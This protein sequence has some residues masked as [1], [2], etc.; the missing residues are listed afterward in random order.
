MIKVNILGKAEGFKLPTVLGLDLNRLSLR[1]Y[2]AVIIMWYVADYAVFET[3]NGEVSAMK[4][5][6]LM[7]QNE[8]NQLNATI[9]KNAGIKSQIEE[10]K[11]Q[12]ERLKNRSEQVDKI[13]QSKSNPFR[14]LERLARNIPEDAWFDTIKFTEDKKVIIEGAAISH[15]SIGALITVANESS[16]FGKSLYI[17]DTS[18]VEEDYAGGKRRVEKFVIEGN[19]VSFDPWGN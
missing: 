16:Y 13:F 5:K 11:A 10:F 6:N 18:T 14:V 4:E 1:G 19:I 9:T 17:K 8:V 12:L 15:R 2:L 7:L 3:W